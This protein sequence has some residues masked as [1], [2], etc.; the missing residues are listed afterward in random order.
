MTKTLFYCVLLLIAIPG[1]AKQQTVVLI[2]LDGFRWDYIEKHNGTIATTVSKTLD[3]LIIKDDHATGVKIEKAKELGVPIITKA[4]F[5][6]E[7]LT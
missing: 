1:I 6:T 3:L 2:S 5:I 4:A 7:H